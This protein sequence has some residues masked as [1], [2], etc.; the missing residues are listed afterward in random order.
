MVTMKSFIKAKQHQ[1]P[2]VLAGR[3]P[4]RIEETGSRGRSFNGETINALFAEFA[5]SWDEAF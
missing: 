4:E 1:L 2:V 3:G 5:G